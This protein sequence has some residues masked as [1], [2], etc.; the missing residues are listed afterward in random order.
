[1]FTLAERLQAALAETVPPATQADLARACGVKAPSVHDWVTGKTKELKGTSLIRAANFLNVRQEWL[2]EGKGPKRVESGTVDPYRMKR[3]DAYVPITNAAASM[4]Y[5][6]DQPEFEYVVDYVR[7]S[8]SWIRTELPYVTSIENLAILPAVGS[9]MEPTFHS[10]DLL[11]I[12]R[13]V[14][15]IRNDAIYVFSLDNQLFVKRML[16]NPITKTIVAKSDNEL[17]G[18]FEIDNSHADSLRVLGLV[19]YRWKGSRL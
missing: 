19:V 3:D 15:A 17:H 1:M 7:M 11:V 4:G 14:D 10:G 12:D 13:G 2:A 6:R 5:G 16:R 8:R 18:S 9:S